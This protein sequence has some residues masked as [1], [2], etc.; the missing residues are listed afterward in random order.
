MLKIL[1]VIFL[2]AL[3]QDTTRGAERKQKVH[4]VTVLSAGCFFINAAMIIQPIT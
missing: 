2:F 3:S 1:I 4:C